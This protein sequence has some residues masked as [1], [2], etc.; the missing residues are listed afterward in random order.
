MGKNNHVLLRLN[1]EELKQMKARIS[2]NQLIKLTENQSKILA[3]HTLYYHQKEDERSMRHYYYGISIYKTNATQLFQQ[4]HRLV[5]RSHQQ[6]LP[7]Y[8]SKDQFLYM[9]VDLQP[10]GTIKSIYSG[11]RRNPHQLIEEDIQTIQ[12]RFELFQ[13]LLGQTK[14][15]SESYLNLIRIITSENKFNTEHVVPQSWFQAKEPMKGDLHH[16]F[17]CQPACNAKRSN[18]PYFD[19]PDYI[20]ESPEEAIRNHCGVS[21]F[22]RFEP[23]YGKGAVARAMLYFLLRYP[24]KINKG[25]RR[26]IDIHLLIRWHEQFPITLYERHRNRAIFLI[27][28]NRNPFIDFPELT[29]LIDIYV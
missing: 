16:L 24:K 14:D 7:Y 3:D 18:Y 15:T 5:K 26:K 21:Q 2:K 4:L 12:K 27:Q 13:E 20:P 17:A 11:E 6:K 28:G 19:F 22:D 25:F 23:E 1:M 29:K 9:W 8:I 10:D